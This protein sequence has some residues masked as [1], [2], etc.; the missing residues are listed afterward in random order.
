MLMRSLVPSS[1]MRTRTRVATPFF[2]S[3]SITLETWIGAS[4]SMMPLCSSAL[5]ALRCRFTTLTPLIVTR[6]V[7]VYTRITS[8]VLPLSSPRITRTVSPLVM[9]S[10][11]RSTLSACRLRFTARG[12]SVLRYFR[13]RMLQNLRR[14]RDDL[15]VPLLAQL[16]RDGTED[17]RGARLALIVDDDHGV[18]VEADVAAV[19]TAR[20]LHRAD[21]DRSRDLG[22]LHRA[23]RQRVLHRDDHEVA[24]AGV[25]PA[26]AAKDANDQG[27]LRA[28]VVRDFDHRFLLNH[29]SCS[30]VP[31]TLPRALDDLDEPPALVL[32]QRTRFSDAHEVPRLRRVLLVVRFQLGR[33]RDH[34]PVDGMRHA[35]LDRHD[36]GLLHLVAHDTAQAR[37]AH[38]ALRRFCFGHISHSWIAPARPALSSSA[39]CPCE[40][41][42]NATGSPGARWRCETAGGNALPPAPRRAP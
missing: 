13:M 29:R 40:S 37:F 17:A 24:E 19:L 20:L 42:A 28:R 41:C 38:A 35:P 1:S 33:V 26:R 12:R 18:L 7:L 32:G 31:C 2:G 15:H 3:M 22:L 39:R 36:N 27:A 16:A 9:R 14:E 4:S 6:P 34:L 11:T 21:D 23:V 8:P 25:T 10:F 30:S 5:R